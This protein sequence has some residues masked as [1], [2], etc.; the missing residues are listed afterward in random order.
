M[1]ITY[2]ITLCMKRDILN[3]SDK[4]TESQLNISV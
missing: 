4:T 3:F 1:H 2:N